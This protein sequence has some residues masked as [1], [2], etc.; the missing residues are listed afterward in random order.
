MERDVP[1]AEPIGLELKSPAASSTGVEPTLR[2]TLGWLDLTSIGVGGIIGA[3]I[4]V[5]TGQAAA[6]YAGPA[7][8]ISFLVA[9]IS[10]AFSALC[11]SELTSMIP[12]AGSAYSFATATLG[13]LCGFC[14]G[15]DLILEYLFGAATVAVGWSGY[16]A[17]V[18]KDMG[19]PLP[20]IFSRAPFQV[21]DG[22]WSASGCILNVPAVVI[23]LSMTFLQYRGVQESAK[24]NNWMVGVKVGVLILFL[25]VGWGYTKSENWSPFIPP[26]KNGHFGGWGIIQGSSVVFFSFIGFDAISTASGE[27]LNPQRDI[28]T[29]TLLSLGLCTVFY[30][31]VGTCI[32]GLVPYQQLDVADPIAVAV[33]AAGGG[34]SWLRPIVKLGALFGLTSVIMVLIGGMSRIF[35]SMAEDGLLPKAFAAIHPV[36]RTPTATICITG[37]LASVIAGLFPVDVLGEMVS[38]GTLSAF[39]VV[40]LGVVALRRS[41]PTLPRPF[42]VPWSPY[43]PAAGV[44]TAVLQITA[45]PL[46]T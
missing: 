7:I 35:F 40:C 25:L 17:S 27:A 23:V 21:I 44:L 11:Y 10:C 8:S 15:W 34:L 19:I 4:Y 42:K 41:A 6:R 13:E 39:V 36:Y 24:F 9:G 16:F 38:I 29:A 31:A 5:L 37:A 18:C 45:L 30:I 46:E 12:V 22:H 43:V 3:G 2:R 14:M 32:T 33:D 1:N 26:A 28:P 20:A